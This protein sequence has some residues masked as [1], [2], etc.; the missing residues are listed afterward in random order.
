[1]I[2][3]EITKDFLNF[4]LIDRGLSG[5]TINSYEFDLQTFTKFL[6]ESTLEI[7]TINK[8]DLQQFFSYLYDLGFKTSTVARHVATLRT[9]Y[10]FLLTEGHIKN[11]PCEL[12]ETPKLPKNL[13]T[14]LTLNE[15]TKLLE[16]LTDEN[17]N[18]IRNKAM[19]ELLYASGMRVSEL[20]DLNISDLYLEMGFVRCLGKGN[21][22]RI[23]PIGEIAT[24]ALEDYLTSARGELLKQDKSTEALFLNRLGTRLTRQGFWKILKAQAQIAGIKK[25]VSPHKLRHSFATHLIENGADLR[26]VQ[27]L[28]GHSDISTTQIYTHISNSHLKKVIDESHPRSNKSRR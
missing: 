21:K 4:L 19:I 13:P 1:M 15:V 24:E 5:N 10:N 28:L 26:I 23:I 22:E 7:T 3:G 12:I 25:D 17:F 27:E 18:D 9:F 2:A 16:S 6:D 14:I 11:N 20:L 8:R